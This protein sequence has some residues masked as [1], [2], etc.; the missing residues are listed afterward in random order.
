MTKSIKTEMEHLAAIAYGEASVK[1]NREEMFAIASVLVR[2]RNARGYTDITTFVT[3]DTT[4]SFV[5]RDG[6]Q[7]YNKMMKSSDDQ[8]ARDAGMRLGVEAAKNALSGGE[9]KS[10]GAYFWDGADIKSKYKTHFKVGKGIKFTEPAHNIYGIE[11]S[12][13]INVLTKIVTH[14]NKKTGVVSSTVVE[15]GRHDHVYESTAAHGGT[16]FWKNSPHYLKVVRGKE[17][18]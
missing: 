10:N 1:D 9:D 8:I 6:N 15:V 4:F 16:I 3:K 18:Q 13:W 14:K 17:H 7:R 5:I 11:E 12:V 2:Q